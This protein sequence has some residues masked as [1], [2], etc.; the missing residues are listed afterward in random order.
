MPCSSACVCSFSSST[1][2]TPVPETDWYVETISRSIPAVSR[3]GFSATISCIVEQFGLAIRP[4]WR[5]SACGLTSLTTS[6]MSSSRRKRDELS[7][8]TQPASTK[9]RAHSPDVVA[10]ALN[11][12]RSKPWIV[13]SFNGCTVPAPS[14]SRPAE[15]SDANGTSSRAGKPRSRSLASMTVPTAPVAPTTATR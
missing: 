13:S 9:R 1:A 2:F 11:S 14:S 7:T 3:I 5:S 10:P 8:T 4:L 6:G 15:R 12:A